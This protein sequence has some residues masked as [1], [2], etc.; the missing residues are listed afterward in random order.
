MKKKIIIGL[1]IYTLFFLLCGIYIIYII[2][3]ATTELDRLITLHQV[4]I[5]REHYL[6]QVKR[7]QTDLTLKD[8]RHKRTFDTVVQNVVSMGR[9][10][11]TCFDCHHNQQATERLQDL[12][13]Q[14][15]TYKDAL[16]RVL[17][18]RANTARI[19]AEED[20]AFQIGEDLIGKVRDVIAI[21]S[22]K[23]AE[24]T[25]RA[26]IRIART[27]YM[28]YFLVGIGPLMSAFL[29]YIFLSGL[30][31]PVNV[32]LDSTRKLKAGNLDHRVEALKDEFGELAASF[33]EMAASLKEQML[34]MQRTEQMVIVG[35]LAAGLAH[36]IK[37]PLAG[38]KV[39]MHV[40]SEE[41][42]MSAED[43]EVIRKV[44]QE[45]VRVESLMRNFLN[46]AKPAKP[47]LADLNVNSLVNTV[48]AFY[49]KSRPSAPDRPNAVRIEKDLQPLPETMADPMQL[50]QIFL[51]LVLNA[52]DAMPNGGTLSVRTSHEKETDFLRIEFADTGK[53]I[54]RENIE[55]IFQPFFTTKPK[56]TGL[57]LAI[58]KQ[59][60]EQHG[61]EISA[62]DNPGGGTVFRI[63]LPVAAVAAETAT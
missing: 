54:P 52:V 28:L 27:K 15:E 17:T 10:V 8:T 39:A 36:E 22:S 61:G 19:L 14:T 6:L 33:N 45:V 43:R 63:L 29:G 49:M 48:L 41:T 23:L 46:F 53:G 47:Q 4:E 7:V 5:L 62:A 55:K 21:T 37:N 32:L 18:L 12:K 1:G 30:T 44:A 9:I 16:S 2:Q 38:I 50:Q 58:S 40:L 59:L 3:S 26:M 25:Q 35:E 42:S 56:G 31:N 57:G 34:K 20:A 11:D 24:N 51:N 13:K 60:I